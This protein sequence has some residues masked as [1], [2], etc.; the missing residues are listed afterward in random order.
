MVNSM[1][2]FATRTGTHGD[3]R[4]VWELRG[5]NGRGLDLRVRVPDGCEV[6]DLALRGALKTAFARGTI[7]ANLKVSRSMTAGR[8]TLNHDALAT[9][10]DAAGRVEAIAAEVG[11][12]LAPSR[13]TDLLA[14]KGVMDEPAQDG[15]LAQAW[16]EVAKQSIPELVQ[17]FATARGAEGAAL[18]A[19]LQGQIESVSGLTKE[20]QIAAAARAPETAE[21]LRANVAKVLQNTSSVDETRLAQEL[22]ILSVKSDVTEEL[23][24][25]SAHASAAQ[26]LVAFD[27]PIGR[28]FDFLMQEFNREA[29]TLCSK[30]GSRELT[31][32]GLDLKTLIDQMREQVQNVE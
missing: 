12:H 9:A 20:A 2:A 14:L 24:R 27:G 7:Q 4:W 32:I 10:I 19:I 16:I 5:V 3:V 26:E 29:N 6:L 17:D 30:S 15:P 22:A 28:K 13:A 8:S 23:D 1:T 18:K 25:L 11:L 31:R 21:K